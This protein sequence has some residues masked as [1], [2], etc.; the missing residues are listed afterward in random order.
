[1]TEPKRTSPVDVNALLIAMGFASPAESL[2]TETAC[3]LDMLGQHDKNPVQ[4]E[5]VRRLTVEIS[6]VVEGLSKS[7][8]DTGLP[9][10]KISVVLHAIV[11]VLM[12]QCQLAELPMP[13]MWN[14]MAIVSETASHFYDGALE[15][16]ADSTQAELEAL[17][18]PIAEL[19]A[20]KA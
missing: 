1:M 8:K 13:P 17:K 9:G 6:D 19:A 2:A 20:D 16:K 18:R 10:I 12:R 4:L 14:A 5:Q 15:V 11:N 7:A 3:I